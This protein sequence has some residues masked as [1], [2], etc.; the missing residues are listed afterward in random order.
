M[1]KSRQTQPEHIAEGLAALLRKIET[2]REAWKYEQAQDE[3]II[4]RGN[5]INDWFLEVFGDEHD[6]GHRGKTN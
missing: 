4:Q 1:A 2:K 6:R 5:E 3:W